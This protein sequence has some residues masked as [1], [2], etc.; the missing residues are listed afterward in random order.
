MSVATH[1]GAIISVSGPNRRQYW[2][3]THLSA[4]LPFCQCISHEISGN[5]CHKE[6]NPVFLASI[7]SSTELLLCTAGG[8]LDRQ[9]SW[10]LELCGDSWPQLAQLWRSVAMIPSHSTSSSLSDSCHLPPAA[11]SQPPT[12]NLEHLPTIPGDDGEPRP[13]ITQAYPSN[14][15]QFNTFQDSFLKLGDKNTWSYIF[16]YLEAIKRHTVKRTTPTL[17]PQLHHHSK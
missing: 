2:G 5:H 10:Q 11:A 13:F 8:V 9:H 3:W 16:R 14:Y 7:F 6:E 1:P 15:F 4:G 12:D 17:V